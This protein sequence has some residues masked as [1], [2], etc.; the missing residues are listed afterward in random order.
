LIIRGFYDSVHK[1]FLVLAYIYIH[2]R[3]YQV[4]LMVDTGASVTA[5]LDR[6]AIRIFGDRLGKLK[7]ASKA[8][9]GIGGFADTY[10]VNNV[11]IALVDIMDPNTRYVIV[12][13]RLFIVTHHKRF[14]G[15]EWKRV[16]Q[17]PS[18]LGMDV[19]LR[20]KRVI[21]DFTRK[22]PIVEIEFP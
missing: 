15:E 20:A 21:F 6:D 18:L 3:A 2:D 17:M 10:I 22:P 1:Y 12:L 19:L 9:V 7:K 8:L 13:S 14:R 11:K 16:S 5:L 4:N